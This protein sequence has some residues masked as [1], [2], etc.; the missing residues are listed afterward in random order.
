MKS[1]RFPWPLSL[2]QDAVTRIEV[3]LAR[4]EQNQRFSRHNEEKIMSD[5]ANLTAAAAA[6]QDEV[7]A[8][9]TQ[10]DTM[11]A[12]LNAAIAAN[13]MQA[14]RD[15]TASIQSSVDALK[16]ASARDMPPGTQP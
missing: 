5:Q 10:M 1:F 7:A 13:D 4:I 11:L 6:L 2:L 3:S 14:V 15:A 9:G 8:I 16:A 12:A